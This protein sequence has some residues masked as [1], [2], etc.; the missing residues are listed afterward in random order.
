M[1]YYALSSDQYTGLHG[2]VIPGTLRD[3]LYILGN[4]LEQ[5]TVLKPQEIMSDTAGYSDVV[6][7]LFHLL[8]YQFSPRIADIGHTR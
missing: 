8:G 6:F 7:G 3:S 1:T 5:K 2:R 4:L